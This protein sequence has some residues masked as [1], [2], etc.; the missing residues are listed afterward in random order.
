VSNEKGVFREL[1]ERQYGE[2]IGGGRMKM[3]NIGFTRE[4]ESNKNG[5]E[6]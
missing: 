2:G 4:G 1:R 3:E 5:G 6:A